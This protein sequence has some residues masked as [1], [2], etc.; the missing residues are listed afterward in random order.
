M[1]YFCQ[2]RL[3]LSY[4]IQT[5]PFRMLIKV[6]KCIEFHLP[7]YKIPQPCSHY[8]E[9]LCL[10]ST[11]YGNFGFCLYGRVALNCGNFICGIFKYGMKKLRNFC[12]RINILG[13]NFDICKQKGKNSFFL[14]MYFIRNLELQR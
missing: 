3:K 11:N 13:R 10:L 2:L 5:N 4:K 7:H 14:Q 1:P 8:Y 6:Q 12:V 9:Y